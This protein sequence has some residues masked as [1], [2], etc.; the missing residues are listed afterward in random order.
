MITRT[1][2]RDHVYLE[3]LQRIYR[4]DIPA[5]VRIKDSTIASDLGVSRT[6][7]REA[8]LRLARD[9]VLRGEPGRGFRVRPLDPIELQEVGAILG[10]LEPLALELSGDFPAPRLDRLRDLVRQLERTR[11][12]AGRCVDLDDDWHRTLLEG[13]PN[14]RLLQLIVTL[15]Q[16]PRR[17]LHAYLQGAGRVSLATV[18]HAK[19][20]ES[21]RQG[22][23]EG[24]A[25]LLRRQWKKGVEELQRSLS[26]QH[27]Q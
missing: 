24:A 18:Y 6:P 2:L 21:L 10:V 4:G 20:V 23:R 9:G 13:C 16:I 5:G 11:G 12:D 22:D 17:Y 15:R 7:V 3:L 14:Q 26:L 1:P 8:L 25:Q 27:S 19:I